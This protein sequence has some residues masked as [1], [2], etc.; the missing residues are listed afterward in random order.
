MMF[1]FALALICGFALWLKHRE[2]LALQA[3]YIRLSEARARQDGALVE[4]PLPE[5]KA[6]KSEDLQIDIPPTYWGGKA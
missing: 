6:S 3:A 4:T 1:D 2:F 5:R